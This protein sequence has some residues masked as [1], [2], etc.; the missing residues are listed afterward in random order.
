MYALAAYSGQI[1]RRQRNSDRNQDLER[2]S[3]YRLHP[4]DW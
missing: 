3:N 1:H 4:I 2:E